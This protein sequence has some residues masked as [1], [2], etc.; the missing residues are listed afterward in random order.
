M[1]SM[2]NTTKNLSLALGTLVFKTGNQGKMISNSN[3]AW[4]TLIT[5]EGS[6]KQKSK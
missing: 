4:R 5:V 6:L 1:K 2:S 3:L